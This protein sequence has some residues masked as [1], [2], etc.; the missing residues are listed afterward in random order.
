MSRNQIKQKYTMSYRA[1]TLV[2]ITSWVGTSEGR[3]LNVVRSVAFLCCKALIFF[4]FFSSSNRSSLKNACEHLRG[5][6]II[7]RIFRHSVRLN[8]RVFNSGNDSLKHIWKSFSPE[9]RQLKKNNI[10][11][12]FKSTERNLLINIAVKPFVAYPFMGF[13][14]FQ[15]IP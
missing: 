15:Q 13:G 6:P 7:L 3:S 5:F 2:P 8:S 14:Q 11:I 12:I 4:R 1:V 10:R 9:K